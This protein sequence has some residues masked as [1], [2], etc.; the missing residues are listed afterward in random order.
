MSHLQAN[1]FSIFELE[2]DLINST[3]TRARTRAA[4]D[5][6]ASHSISLQPRNKDKGK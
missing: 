3:S 2:F 4:H 5:S 1:E 6:L